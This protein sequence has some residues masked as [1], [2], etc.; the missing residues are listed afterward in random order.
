MTFLIL[1]IFLALFAFAFSGKFLKSAVFTL[2]TGTACLL[3]L[4]FLN[5]AE[6]MI[7]S[8]VLAVSALLYGIPGIIGTLILFLT[9]IF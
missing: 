4:H 5:P 8:P 3:L 2:F 1:I 9:N 6:G 7:F